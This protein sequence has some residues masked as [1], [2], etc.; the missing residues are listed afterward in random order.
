VGFQGVS[1]YH[2]VPVLLDPDVFGLSRD[3]LYRTLWAENV[4]ARRYFSPG[5][6]RM[7]AYARTGPPPSL[8]AT[9][10]IA[11][12]ILCFPSGFA[13]PLPTVERILGLVREAHARAED[14]R[15]R[16]GARP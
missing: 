10:A 1:N 16:E 6:H 13:E 3:V 7:A 15:R 5:L 2:Y 11:D 12:R 4:L 8:P 14:L 9:E